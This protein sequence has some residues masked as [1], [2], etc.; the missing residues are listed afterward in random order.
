[1][2][3]PELTTEDSIFGKTLILRKFLTLYPRRSLS[4]QVISCLFKNGL[5]QDHAGY[6]Q[7]LMQGQHSCTN[8]GDV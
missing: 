7:N 2:Q 4:Y 5:A 6:F 8:K 1:M 3:M